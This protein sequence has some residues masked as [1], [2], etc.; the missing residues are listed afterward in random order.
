MNEIMG[1]NYSFCRTSIRC[2]YVLSSMW[3][4]TQGNL[5]KSTALLVGII[6]GAIQ[7]IMLAAGMIIALYPMLEI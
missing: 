6:F 3:G 4:S 7:T 1:N 2:I 5:K